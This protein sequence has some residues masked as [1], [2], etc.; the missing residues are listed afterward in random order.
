[1]CN[2]PIGSVT[3]KHLAMNLDLMDNSPRIA[4]LLVS[5]YDNQKLYGMVDNEDK[6]GVKREVSEAITELFTADISANDQEVISDVLIGMMRQVEMDIRMT[7]AEKL[8]DFDNIPL[9]LVLH[10]ANDQIDIARPMLANSPVLS[11]MDLM[12]IIKSQGSEYWQ[13]IAG[14][15]KL[16]DEVIDSLAD[17]K[18]LPTALVLTNN[19]RIILTRHAMDILS[20]VANYNQELSD[21][22]LRRKELPK[23]LADFIHQKVSKQVTEYIDLGFADEANPEI[24]MV[25]E[26]AIHEHA[27]QLHDSKYMPH[28]LL[29]EEAQD[30]NKRGLLNMD[31]M[32]MSLQNGHIDR[33]VA[34]FAVFSGL[35][36]RRI[37][38]FVLQACPKGLAIACKAYGM[39]HDDFSTVYLL[40]HR[41]R[42]DNG[43]VNPSE[44]M[45]ILEYFDG[46]NNIL[47]KRIAQRTVEAQAY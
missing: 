4:T 16:S 28:A 35:S 24:D 23:D 3:G 29:L 31:K 42:S 6:E 47:A 14:R 26:D 46:V 33:F 10:L 2:V 21:P 9:S 37:H 18:D 39:T 5:L 30:D 34:E 20:A 43:V 7:I 36:V 1:M 11:D 8:S 15:Q 40:T 27:P 32:I 12:Y 38:D 25:V 17:T 22:L 13:A 44:V 45:H 19:D 41:A